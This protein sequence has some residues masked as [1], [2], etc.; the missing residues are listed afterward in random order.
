MLGDGSWTFIL[1]A[2]DDGPEPD[3]RG[4]FLCVWLN[5]FDRLSVI[6]FYLFAFRREGLGGA[7]LCWRAGVRMHLQ[8]CGQ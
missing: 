6:Y 4:C 8:C 3:C 7:G 1:S 5:R 2:R